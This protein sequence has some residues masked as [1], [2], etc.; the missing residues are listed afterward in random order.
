MSDPQRETPTSTAW[1]GAVAEIRYACPTPEPGIVYAL[2]LEH[3]TCRFEGHATRITDARH[4][5]AAWSLDANGFELAHAPSDV[6]D[7]LDMAQIEGIYYPEVERL[8]RRVTGAQR[9]LIYSFMVRDDS[10]QRKDTRRAARTA[11]LDY[12]EDSLRLF[13]RQLLGTEAADALFR[14]RWAA[15]NVW[16]P[17]RPVEK[18][19]LAL[20]HARTVGE[21]DFID[22]AMGY[23]PGEALQP[24]V[25]RNLKWSPRQDWYY[26][27]G[28]QPSEALVFKLH[29][30][31]EDVARYT[32]HSAFDDPHA[33]PDA[34]WRI[35]CETRVLVFY[36]D[37]DT[38]RTDAG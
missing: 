23:R 16:R 24:Y 20:C 9:A 15:I 29:D 17:I 31:R 10:G 5:A 37:P 13:G 1:R 6:A 33:S 32:P 30:S 8:V 38:H 34:R 26:F 12:T 35:S 21:G 3:S 22:V 14:Q 4:P 27:S 28:M 25:G 36:G 19:P 7:F 18:T 2:A 11:H